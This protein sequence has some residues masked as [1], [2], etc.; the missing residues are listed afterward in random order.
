M[1]RPHSASPCQSRQPSSRGRGTRWG[2]PLWEPGG[3][4]LEVSSRGLACSQPC[5]QPATH[6]VS[7]DSLVF[8]LNCVIPLVRPLRGRQTGF[9]CLRDGKREAAVSSSLCLPPPRR[10]LHATS[11]RQPHWDGTCRHKPQ[12]PGPHVSETGFVPSQHTLAPLFLKT[13]LSLN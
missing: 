4:L 13:A 2:G 11:P 5:S 1:P 3:N 6:L 7:R 9:R 12:I 8:L 10:L